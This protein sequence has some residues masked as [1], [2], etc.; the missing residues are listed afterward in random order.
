[1]PHCN[2]ILLFSSLS[3]PAF[4]IVG[5][6]LLKPFLKKS[7]I[8]KVM[9]FGYNQDEWKA[10]LLEEIDANQL[11]VEYGG[12][13]TDPGGVPKVKFFWILKRITSY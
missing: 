2:G 11:P 13:V 1:M 7:T 5:F 12:S 8:D 10:A 9:I 3:A 6:N 4:A